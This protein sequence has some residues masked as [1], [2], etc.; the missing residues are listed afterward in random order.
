M[1]L[2]QFEFAC[3]AVTLIG[4][5]VIMAIATIET[6]NEEKISRKQSKKNYGHRQSNRG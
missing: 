3:G 2:E 5:L 6:N 4:S 1:T